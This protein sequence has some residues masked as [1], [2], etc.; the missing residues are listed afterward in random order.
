MVPRL[1]AT[2]ILALL[3]EA[4][5]PIWPGRIAIGGIDLGDTWRHPAVAVDGP[6]HGLVPFHKLSQWLAFSLIEPLQEAGIEVTDIDGLT[7]LAEYR[8]GGLFIDLGVIAPRSAELLAAAHHPGDEA[9][10]EWRALTVCLLDRLAPRVRDVLGLT[11][12]QLPLAGVLEG[13]TWSAGRR[14]AREKRAD[15]GPPIR[16]ISDGSV[17]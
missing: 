3:L 10:V 9:I 12:A 7:G 13:G 14:I 17:F 16:I 2:E 8:N 15:G 5:G 11:P 6:T 1:A 4:L